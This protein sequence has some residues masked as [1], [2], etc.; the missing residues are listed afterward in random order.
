MR[1]LATFLNSLQGGQPRGVIFAWDCCWMLQTDSRKPAL[2]ISKRF[3]SIQ[4]CKMR[5]KL[6]LPFDRADMGLLTRFTNPSA[7]C[8]CVMDHFRNFSVTFTQLFAA[9]RDALRGILGYGIRY[10]LRSCPAAS[11]R[12]LNPGFEDWKLL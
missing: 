11:F 9:M 6:W 7:S 3:N 10:D 2:P 8:D 4:A 12:A 1:C 5:K